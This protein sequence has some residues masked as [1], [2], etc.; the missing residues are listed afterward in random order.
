MFVKKSILKH[1]NSFHRV[2]LTDDARGDTR[3]KFRF[4]FAVINGAMYTLLAIL[5]ASDYFELGSERA[6]RGVTLQTN[7]E[8]AIMCL[9]TFL[10]AALVIAFFVYGL[11]FWHQLA[12][13][14]HMSPVRR[15]IL[16]KVQ[17]LTCLG[18]F[19]FISCCCFFLKNLIES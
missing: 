6:F 9:D 19:H 16:R 1:S 10:Y 12:T 8:M 15:R 4:M 3:S 18:K 5:Y 11:L 17:F 14:A 2:S 13:I 7:A